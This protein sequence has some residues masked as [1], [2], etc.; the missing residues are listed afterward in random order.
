MGQ[1][2]GGTVV[3]E[4]LEGSMDQGFEL[5]KGGWVASQ[6]L[7]PEF[8]LLCQRSLN[9]L[10]GMLQGGDLGTGWGANANLHGRFPGSSLLLNVST[11]LLSKAFSGTTFRECT[12]TRR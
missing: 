7:G 8:L 10:K 9:F 12:Q 3:G 6:L 11:I 5:S 4:L 2:T 1:E